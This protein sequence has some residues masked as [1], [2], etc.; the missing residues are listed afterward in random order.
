VIRNR[1]GEVSISNVEMDRIIKDYY[2]ELYYK[3]DDLE[4]MDKVLERYNFPR[5]NK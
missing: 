1:K 4:E 5:L 3:V 2:E